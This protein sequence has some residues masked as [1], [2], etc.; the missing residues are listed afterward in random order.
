[1]V[2]TKEIV[3]IGASFGGLQLVKDLSAQLPAHFHIT[4]IDPRS[5]FTWTIALPRG[6]VQPEFADKSF[7]PLT[8]F[9]SHYPNAKHVQG[10][11]ESIDPA[12]KE[13]R[14]RDGQSIN[15]EYLVIASG[16]SSASPWKGNPQDT[17]PDA[18][19]RASLK[20]SAEAIKVSRNSLR[21]TRVTFELQNASTVVIGGAGPIG[22]E[23]AAEIKE[24]YPEKRVV[25]VK[26]VISS[27]CSSF[28]MQGQLAQDGARGWRLALFSET[29][30]P[31]SARH[32]RD[33]NHQFHPS[34]ITF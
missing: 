34:R 11:V 31:K 30:G 3:V 6:I 5:E 27:F 7:F 9:F 20:E 13:V 21:R 16:A 1:M 19:W 24:S 26:L 10:Y 23:T 22:I 15:Y 28:V 18:S 8:K 32:E 29:E 4:V 33:R 25:L 12:S 14:L 17:N 2:S